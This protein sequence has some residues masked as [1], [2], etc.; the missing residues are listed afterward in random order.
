[1][2]NKL[3]PLPVGVAPGSGYWN[4]WYEKLRTLVNSFANGFPWSSVTGTPTTLSGY[5]I[6]DGMSTSR[7]VNT[8]APLTG[9]GNLTIDRTLSIT[10]F[11]GTAPGSVPTS[12]GGTSNFLRADGTWAPPGG[13]GGGSGNA[14]TVSVD[15]GASFTDKATTVV[16]EAWITATTNIVVHVLPSA[17]SDE[18]YL[19]DI[20]PVVS[21]RTAGSFNLTL[22][23]EPE[24][25]G[26]YEVM[27]LGV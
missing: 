9:G 26:V 13:G 6:T 5:G 25:K 18:M 3:P 16:S 11:S 8:T 23:S 24:A 19:L 17:D 1:M 22:Y 15:F 7:Q 14:V 27:C 21:N 2:A 12:L 4:D 20:K 10:Q